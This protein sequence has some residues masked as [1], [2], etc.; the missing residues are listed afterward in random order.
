[1]KNLITPGILLLVLTTA[2]PGH[3]QT[4]KWLYGLEAGGSGFTT[5]FFLDKSYI[6]KDMLNQFYDP[7]AAGRFSMLWGGARVEK[8]H[9]KWAFGGGLNYLQ[10]LS[11]ISKSGDPGYYYVLYKTSDNSVE[12]VRTRELSQ[13]AAYLAIPLEVKYY[14]FPMENSFKIY[15]SAGAQMGF[16]LNFKNAVSFQDPNMEQH[17]VD[18]YALLEKPN[19]VMSTVNLGGGLQWARPSGM[20]CTLGVIL[21]SMYVGSSS[22]MVNPIAGVGIFVRV[23][24][25]M[26]KYE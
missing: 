12:Y 18:V 15:F 3:A 14:P 5:G 2:V 22:Q 11:S 4:K 16:L 6:R 10:T 9:G 7:N 23:Q 24:M 17:A 25:P 26:S 1:M 19:G 21:P 8:Q 13:S 20:V